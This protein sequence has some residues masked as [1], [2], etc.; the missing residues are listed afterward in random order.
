MGRRSKFIRDISITCALI[1]GLVT[2]GLWAVQERAIY[3]GAYQSLPEWI[4]LVRTKGTDRVTIPVGDGIDLAALYRRPDLGKPTVIVFHGNA[5]FPEDYGFLYKSWSASGYGI[6]A[7]V[8]RGFPRSTGEVSGDGILRDALSVYDWTIHR[9]PSSPVVVFGQSLGTASAVKVAANREVSGVVLVSPFKSM[10]DVVEGKFPLLPV[11][12]ALRSPLR[13][14]ME[15]PRVTAPVII[16]HGDHD[17]LVPI[18]SGRELASLS[19]TPPEFLVVE[20]AGHIEGLFG[21]AMV[22]EINRFLSR[23][24]AAPVKIANRGL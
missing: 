1:Y 6:V 10:L 21:N 13:S 7:P 8:Y 5:G 17:E 22:R 2:A 24:S 23:V 3:P 19:P 4:N 11:K 20:G 9:E 14:D 15:M 12:A 18:S 16:F